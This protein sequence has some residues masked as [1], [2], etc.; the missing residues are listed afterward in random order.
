[1]LFEY[2]DDQ[3]HS[4][5]RIRREPDLFRLGV[6]ERRDLSANLLAAREPLVPMNVAII[7]HLLL[8]QLT[9]LRGRFREWSSRRR[10]QIHTTARHRK[11]RAYVS[12]VGHFH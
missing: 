5:R 10:V 7:H 9:G 12:P 4:T 11:L 3:I 2:I 8:V 1:M 6:D